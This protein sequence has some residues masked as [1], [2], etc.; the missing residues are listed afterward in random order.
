VPRSRVRYVRGERHHCV[1]DGH[2]WQVVHLKMV[3]VK[4]DICRAVVKERV[5]KCEVPVCGR[6]MC[7]KCKVSEER[8]RA[9]AAVDSW[10]L[11]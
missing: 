5:W 11:K 9:R 8:M 1:R 4:C 10:V 3:V 2:V 7:G 6:E